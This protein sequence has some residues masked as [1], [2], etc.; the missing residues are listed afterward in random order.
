MRLFRLLSIAIVPTFLALSISVR[1]ADTSGWI[2]VRSKN[3]YL[4]GNAPEKE[5]RKVGTKL[6]QFRESFRLLFASANLDSQV[7]TNVVVFKNN[8]SYSPFKPRRSD[9]RI[10]DE[11]AGYFQSGEDVNYITF[12]VGGNEKDTYGTIFHEYVHF[13]I[14]A[15]FKPEIP[16]W[17]NEGIAE[18]YQTYEITGD[19]KIKLGQPQEGHV[20]LL[21]KGGMM[22]L[23]QLLNLTNYQLG[24]LS[25]R[26]REMFYAQSWAL[27]HYLTQTGRSAALDKFLKDVTSGVAAKTAFQGAFQSSYEQMEGQLRDYIIRN[28]YNFQEI[29]LKKKLIFDADMQS[30]P[31]DE[32]SANAHLGELL[33]Q[34]Q[35]ADEAEPYLLAALKLKPELPIANSAMGKLK[36]SQRKFDE[37]RGFLEKAIAG[38]PKDHLAYYRYANLLGR[39]N[40]DEYGFVSRIKPET[41]EKMRSALR[42]AIAIAPTFAD[43]Y[44]LLAFVSFVNNEN[45]DE[46]ITLLQTAL[47][48]QPNNLRYSLRVAEILTRQN[49]FDD[50]AQ[51]AQKVAAAATEPD[52]K[53]RANSLVTQIADL[54]AFAV[55]QEAEKKAFEDRIAASGETPVTVKR[56]ESPRPPTE[57]ELA[58]QNDHI[59]I[60]AINEALRK[61]KDG[62]QRVRG[63]VTRIDCRKRPLA[64]TVKTPTETF[65]V[66]SKDFNDLYL[67]AHDPPAMRK[68]IGCEADVSAFSALVTYRGVAGSKAAIRGELVAI[69]FIPADFRFMTDEEMRTATLIIYEQEPK[70]EKAPDVITFSPLTTA[71][72]ANRSVIATR[73]INNALMK[74]SEGQR[75][76]M[77]FLDKIECTDRGSV[78]HL[79]VGTETRKLISYSPRALRLYVFTPDLGD[80]QLVCGIKPIEFPA[81]FV[82]KPNAD[83]K[84]GE[85]VSVEFVPKS[86]VL[87]D[88]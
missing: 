29:T 45:L 44:E 82:Y 41:A 8:A 40:R 31:L 81:V 86:F 85:L 53:S 7:P 16:Q 56:I 22:T 3:F 75:R 32:A 17:F 57:E 74:P 5:I 59:R 88:R 38:D 48:Y 62:E 61:T 43:S 23:E 30:S 6:E 1:A 84:T 51:L 9:G 54:K 49:K 73:E 87:E 34:S 80:T 63:N 65:T 4:I 20:A 47:K 50:A 11:I 72:E 69:E 78:Y 66:T 21:Q 68:Q 19:V 13:I 14:N 26:T 60:R 24:Q 25:G 64:Y 10:D 42:K 71:I 79:R 15:N 70:V 76:E 33:Y 2:Q 27:V 83:G 18:Y 12:A 46:A 28:S 36:L 52:I 35:R 37:A 67:R 55:R 58:K 39:E 77:G